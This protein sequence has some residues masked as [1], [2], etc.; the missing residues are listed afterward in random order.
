MDQI[1]V[2][3]TR[4]FQ[5]IS[6]FIWVMCAVAL[7]GFVFIVKAQS[8]VINPNQ[9]TLTVTGK[10]ERYV[11]PDIARIY[12]TESQKAL[13]AVL[14]QEAA[15]KKMNAATEYLKSVGVA[16]KDIKTTNYQIYPVYEYYYLNESTGVRC[17]SGYCP[18]PYI[19]K[20][21]IVAYRVEQGV[22]V[23]VRKVAAAGKVVAGLGAVGIQNIGGLSLEIEAVDKI[24][25]EV[26]N[27]AIKDARNKARERAKSLGVSLGE[28]I[29]VSDNYGGPIYYGRDV[30]SM[31]AK[32]GLN[33][34]GM[35]GGGEPV[36]AAP[37]INPGQNQI[38][39]TV[40]VVY[41]IQ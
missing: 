4:L 30:I 35:G 40:T 37:D 20:E 32:V 25:E 18:P 2:A 27:E 33:A 24:T 29:S 12:F 13:T 26:K 31:E 16:E 22:E 11:A 5:A 15:T 14:A 8:A 36:P 10:S 1:T 38:E 23:K 39:S 41:E 7:A 17:Y 9:G 19:Q 21:N 6:I 3:K 28:V 34:M